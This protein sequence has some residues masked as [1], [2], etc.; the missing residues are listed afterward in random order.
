MSWLCQQSISF[1]GIDRILATRC[2]RQLENP[3]SRTLIWCA[4]EILGW[5]TTLIF[6]RHR[7]HEQPVVMK[8]SAK[9]LTV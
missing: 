7:P 8:E 3:F 5:Q 2:V 4:C 6:L 9:S 1:G